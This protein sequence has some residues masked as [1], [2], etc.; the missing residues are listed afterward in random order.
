MTHCK[1]CGKEL[2]NPKNL[3]CSLHAAA[4]LRKLEA[5]G[6]LA[7]RTIPMGGRMEALH[8]HRFLTIRDVR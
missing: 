7:P 8:K 1:T 6:Y 3:Y 2:G 5:S 4:T